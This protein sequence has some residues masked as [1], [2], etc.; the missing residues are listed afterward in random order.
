[1]EW[2]PTNKS[3]NKLGN[4]IDGKSFTSPSLIE[5]ENNTY[6]MLKDNQIFYLNKS[7]S[8]WELLEAWS[9][10]NPSMPGRRTALLSNTNGD[11]FIK[12]YGNGN[13]NNYLL[14]K[15]GTSNWIEIKNF[16]EHLNVLWTDPV[17]FT[18]KG[19]LYFQASLQGNPHLIPEMYN[20]NTNK[21]ELVFDKTDQTNFELLRQFSFKGL[22]PFN[23]HIQA[24]GTIFVTY[25]DMNT[26]EYV[27]YK[28]SSKSYPAKAEK[29][30]TYAIEKFGHG[31]GWNTSLNIPYVT[32]K[33]E[34]KTF[35]NCSTF[36]DSHMSEVYGMLDS[37][38][39]LKIY[40]HPIVRYKGNNQMNFKGDLYIKQTES[41]YLYRW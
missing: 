8:T 32:P 26:N 6:Y 10:L 38:L 7:N 28:F 34:L 19:Y 17:F 5:D 14:R 11:I 9:K 22:N 31:S 15:A 2:N 35:I 23:Y 24:E 36:N 16:P 30:Q 3:W 41:S 25:E 40:G 39:P 29:V 4:L 27:I 21:A 13:Y 37:S 18:N 1:M 12:T 33:G 20:I